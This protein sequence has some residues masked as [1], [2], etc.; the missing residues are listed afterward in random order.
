MVKKIEDT[1][2]EK[3]RVYCKNTEK[4]YEIQP[5]TSLASFMDEIGINALA[6]HVDNQLKELGYKLYMDHS[7]EFLDYTHSDGRRCYKR[8]LIFILQKALKD[9]YPNKQLILDYTL[10]NGSYGELIENPK[11]YNTQD[12]LK[13]RME[14]VHEL[15]EEEISAIKLKMLDIVGADHRIIKKKLSNEEA[16]ALFE[17]NKQFDKA[18]L[19]KSLGHFFVSV[20]F[21]DGYA[22]TFYGPMVHSTGKIKK[23]NLIKYNKGFCIQFPANHPHYELPYVKYQEKLFNVFKENSNWCNIIGAKD[24]ATINKAITNGYSSQ[25]IQIAEALHERKY[26]AIADQIYSRKD[27]VKLI[28]L[29][30]PSSSGKTTTS[31]RIALH[32]KV[33]GLN[34]VVLAMD[35][36]FVDREQTPKDESGDNGP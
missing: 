8:S 2:M 35:N 1:N 6:A 12:S 5:G 34:P 26:A 4:F 24:I 29:A 10:P 28:L 11:S 23:F 14:T 15:T 31:M 21:L 33:L 13:I 30:G 20:Y 17:A 3:I 7:I 18:N 25:V 22:D 32:L 16:V 19:I 27:Q 9:L 36:Y